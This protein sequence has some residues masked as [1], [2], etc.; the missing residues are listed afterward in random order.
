MFSQYN[1]LSELN[2]AYNAEKKQV[3]QELQELRELK[4]QIRKENEQSY[5]LFL[6]L[7]EKMNYSNE[8]NDKMVRSIEEY[9]YEANQLLRKSEIEL[10]NYKDELKRGYLKQTEKI[11]DG[12]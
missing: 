6:Y 11:E 1:E 7:K 2:N 9:E 4:Y 10:E 3:D 5:D 12:D 8:A